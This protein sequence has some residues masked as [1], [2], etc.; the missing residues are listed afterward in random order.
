MLYVLYLDQFTLGLCLYSCRFFW[1]VGALRVFLCLFCW[2]LYWDA[3]FAADIALL[4]LRVQQRISQHHNRIPTLSLPAHPNLPHQFLQPRQ[5]PLTPTDPLLHIANL[6]L[7]LPAPFPNFLQFL[8]EPMIIILLIII[9]ILFFLIRNL[10]NLLY[11]FILL[12]NLFMF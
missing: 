12:G 10:F 8:Q 7:Y 6:P 4:F 11:S 3:V 5:L 1:H 9:L 2:R